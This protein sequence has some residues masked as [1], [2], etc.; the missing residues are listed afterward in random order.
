M[1]NFFSKLDLNYSTEEINKIK[2]LLDELKEQFGNSFEEIFKTS[3]DIVN[4]LL[5]LKLDIN[6]LVVA[7]I[8]PFVRTKEDCLNLIEGNND[9]KTLLTSVLKLEKIDY[10]DD[11]SEAENL[12]AM[13]VAIAKD[14]RVIIIKLAEVLV[15]AQN[16]K[17]QKNET[18]DKL[19]YEIKEIYAPLAARLGLSFIKTK[20]YDL[21]MAY[22]NNNEY[23][24]LMKTLA[25]DVALRQNTIEKVKQELKN[26]VT[27]LG[28]KG[29][30]AGRI[31]SVYSIYNKTKEKHLQVNQIHDI[32]ALRVFV[33]NVNDCYAVLG[34][35]HTKY[36]PLDGRFKDYIAKPKANGY[37]S[38]HTTVYVDE[39]P[40]EIQIRTYEM[41]NHAEY[42]IAAH[43]LYKEHKSK[44]NNLDDKLMWIRKL[45]ENSG[46]VSASELLDELKTDV[47]SDEIFVQTPQGKIIQLVENSTPIDFAYN[48]HSEV[49]NKC[50]GAKVNGKMVPLTSKLNNGDIV[51]IITST[52]SKGPS[53]DWLKYCKTSQAKSKINSFFKKEMKEEN[54][55]KGKSILDQASKVKGIALHELLNEK[56]LYDVF[57]KYSMKRLDEVFAAVGYGSLTSSQVINKLYNNYKQDHGQDDKKEQVT[58]VSNSQ[59]V[60]DIEGLADIMIKFAKCCNPIPGDEIT[61]FV[62]RGSG[63]TIHRRDCLSLSQYEP[64]RLLQLNWGANNEE[65][66]YVAG[67]KILVTNQAGVLAEI[68]NK[69]SENKININYINSENAK[70]NN[71]IINIGINVKNREQLIDLQNKIQAMNNVLSVIRGVNK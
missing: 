48:I 19:H 60:G 50:V 29:E 57:E 26:M 53:R 7:I 24:R 65:H 8:L 45:I 61:G 70:D 1:E 71:V 15:T 62:S 44:T 46:N 12:R 38:L 34:A 67:L 55:K 69:I 52:N 64:D 43:W 41:H 14:I 25:E 37:Q 18:T 39:L 22:Y 63:V 49:G 47:Y 20:L 40:L 2:H 35:V 6:T 42:G 23:K 66:S 10:T 58:L 32:I 28:I 36:V 21:S 4:I 9:S 51:E 68:T 56:Y 3:N 59:S 17:N 27:Q 5:P 31:K 33:S 11:K 16:V 30:V 54:I 13:F